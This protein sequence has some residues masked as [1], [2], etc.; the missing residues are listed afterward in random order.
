M[1]DIDPEISLSIA[2]APPYARAA[3]G[4]LWTL[5]ARLADIVRTTTEPLIGEMRLT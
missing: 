2:H 3:L 5:D 4:L 1:Y